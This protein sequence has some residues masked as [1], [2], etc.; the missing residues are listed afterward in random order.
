MPKLTVRFIKTAGPG[1]YSDGEH[2]LMLRVAPG[3]SRQFMQRLTIQGK[4]CDIGLGGWP[5]VSLPEA[6]ETAFENRRIARRGGDP[7][8]DRRK[9]AAPTFAE[10]AEATVAVLREG[11]KAG[12]RQ[13]QIWRRAIDEYAM[14]RLGKMRVDT[15]TATDIVAVLSPH[16]QSKH[17][18]ARRVRQRIGAIM[19][20]SQGQG[21]REDNPVEAAS[22]AL[23]KP[24]RVVEHMKALPHGEVA[25]ALA[26]VAASGAWWATKAA[27]AFMVHTAARS[28]EVRGATWAE[29]DL[30]ARIWTVPAARAKIGR[31]ASRSA[32][33]GGSGG[34]GRGARHG[35]R[36][37]ACVPVRHGPA[38][39]G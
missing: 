29:M 12:G 28:G 2:G 36:L 17:E 32:F 16:W 14:P 18:T 23:P 15:I 38:T 30:E 25:A 11:W 4:R 3:G 9:S 6:R 37:R 27:F 34:A 8:A 7:L 39:V 10:A 24:S 26:T 1:R 31:G 20:W 22:A 35:G 5:L 13:E 21:F 19:K 33:P